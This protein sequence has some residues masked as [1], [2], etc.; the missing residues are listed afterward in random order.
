MASSEN[1]AIIDKN[2]GFMKF[3]IRNQYDRDRY[4][5]EQKQKLNVNRDF[6]KTLINNFKNVD[7][8]DE[9]NRKPFYPVSSPSKNLCPEEKGVKNSNCIDI[10]SLKLDSKE[11]MD[12]ER[13]EINHSLSVS[14]ENIFCYKNNENT[15]RS[16]K[17]LLD[18]VPTKLGQ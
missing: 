13:L 18:T 7:E 6:T 14:E 15:N 1:Q 4:D 8:D 17:L 3:I 12:F 10:S 5:K 11:K 9:N 2:H 16:K